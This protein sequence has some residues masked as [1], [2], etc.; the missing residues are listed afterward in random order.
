MELKNLKQHVRTL[1]TLPITEAPV[2]SCYQS[3]F[4]GHLVDRN[5]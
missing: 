2:I 3:L 4:N 5:A 1:I